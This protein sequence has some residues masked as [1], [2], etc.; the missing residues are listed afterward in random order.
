VSHPHK[1][2]SDQTRLCHDQGGER[3]HGAVVTP[4]YQ[5]TLFSFKNWDA[6]D[7]AFENIQES[8]VYSRLLN[9]TVS[10]V[11]QKIADLARGEVAKLCASGM[12][13]ISSAIFHC[14]SA[15][16]H[17]ITINSLYGPANSFI[18]GYLEEKSGITVT[19]VKGDSVEEIKS[20]I[21]PRTKL[22]YLESPS[23]MLFVLQDLQE[24]SKVAKEH[25]IKTVID[26]TWATPLYQ[27]PLELGI[28]IEVHSVSK[29]LC[30]HSDVVAGV[31]ISS[32]EIM[33]DI[34]MKE[35]GLLGG[36]MSPFEAWLILRSMR[37]LQLRMRQHEE[38][39][40][41][42]AA[43]LEAHP[44]IRQVNYPGLASHPQY[45]LGQKQMTG[46]S[47][48]LSIELDTD[49]ISDVKRCVDALDL[50]KIGVSW[51]GHESLIYA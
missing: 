10:D 6:I 31:I 29:Y 1:D 50:F 27:K 33:D 25:N 35:H 15:G 37:T 5:N 30:G 12:A 3:H 48:L 2:L 20:A 43:Y 42:I 16:D 7:D 23:S 28:D 14:V 32:K 11:E 24:I 44:R 4:I 45:A 36:K 18:S 19:Y 26:N 8:Y 17:I 47:G 9:P 34:L 51:G 41:K 46:N 40:A 38:S 49:D 13:A 22:I 21:T 39:T